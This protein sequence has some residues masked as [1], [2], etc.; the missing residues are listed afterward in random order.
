MRPH[1]CCWPRTCTP[2][3]S[4]V[5]SR[6]P[7]LVIDPKPFAGDP[8]SAMSRKVLYS[9]RSATSGSTRAARRAGTYEA[10]AATMPRS[11]RTAA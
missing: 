9:C 4:F 2:G 1:T 7:W 10:R 6:E 3:T 5:Q 11:A 8:V